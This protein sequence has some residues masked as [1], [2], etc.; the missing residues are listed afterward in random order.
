[1]LF[2]PPMYHQNKD[3][4]VCLDPVISMYIYLYCLYSVCMCVFYLSV[5]IYEYMAYS[6]QRGH[7]CVIWG[8]FFGKKGILFAHTPKTDAIFNHF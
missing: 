1:M 2:Q 4:R 8:T 5:F 3:E 7:R 6:R